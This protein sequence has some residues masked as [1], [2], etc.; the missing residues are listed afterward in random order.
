MLTSELKKKIEIYNW[1]CNREGWDSMEMY[2]DGKVKVRITADKDSIEIQHDVG[3]ELPDV[4]WQ[5][6]DKPFIQY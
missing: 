6:A 3:K 1:E 2:V 5:L 4:Y